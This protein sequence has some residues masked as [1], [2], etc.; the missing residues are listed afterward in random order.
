MA[1]KSADF[2][3]DWTITNVHPGKPDLDA[4]ARRCA[5]QCLALAEANGLSRTD[6]EAE[7]GDLVGHLR[8]ALDRAERFKANL[9]VGR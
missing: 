9:Q 8:R 5:D 3:Q 1:S 2:V 6:I 7:V 4:E